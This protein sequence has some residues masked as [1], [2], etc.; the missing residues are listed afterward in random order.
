MRLRFRHLAFTATA[1]ALTALPLAGCSNDGAFTFSGSK[2]NYIG[3][4]TLSRIRPGETD[5]EWVV[6]VLGRPQDRESLSGGAEEIWK[7]QYQ[8][9]SASGGSKRAYLINSRPEK[10][11]NARYIYIQLAGGIVSDWWRD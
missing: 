3:E 6:A 10:G 8:L 4:E 1:F 11:Q 5:I 2:G 7:Y 9:V